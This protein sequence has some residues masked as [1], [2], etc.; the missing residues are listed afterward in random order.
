MTRKRMMAMWE[1]RLEAGGLDGLELVWDM[2]R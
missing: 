1:R 2:E